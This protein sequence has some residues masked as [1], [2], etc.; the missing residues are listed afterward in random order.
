MH[1]NIWNRL[2]IHS[3]R[4]NF[5]YVS[6]DKDDNE[7][8]SIIKVIVHIDFPELKILNLCKNHYKKVQI[9]LIVLKFCNI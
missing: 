8:P 3:K 9:L 2:I 1:I 4:Y 6:Y 5:L 7:M